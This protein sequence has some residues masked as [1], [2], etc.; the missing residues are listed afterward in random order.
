MMNCILYL[1]LVVVVV[2]GFT[3]HSTLVGTLRELTVYSQ[4]CEN[5]VATYV[6]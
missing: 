3:T 6:D 5:F 1:L 4:L 2:V